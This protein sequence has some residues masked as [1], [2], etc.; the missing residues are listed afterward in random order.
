MWTFGGDRPRPDNRRQQPQH[1]AMLP[2]PKVDRSAVTRHWPPLTGLPPVTRVARRRPRSVTGHRPRSPVTGPFIGLVTGPVRSH[3]PGRPSSARLVT[4]PVPG[5]VTGLRP[6]HWSVSVP[7][8]FPV[9]RPVSG[10]PVRS[11][12]R[13]G[14][15]PVTGPVTVRSPVW[16]PARSPVTYKK[17]IYL[18]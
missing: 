8:S 18:Y 1:P 13:P 17:S 3:R 6:G 11:T 10:P 5:P 2:D 12:A 7:V 9:S 14:P 15:G 16:S 4:G